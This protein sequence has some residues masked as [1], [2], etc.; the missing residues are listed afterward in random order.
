MLVLKTPFH[1]VP[2]AIK[3]LFGLI[4]DSMPILGFNRTPYFA[5]NSICGVSALFLIGSLAM[6]K[7]WGVIRNRT[8]QVSLKP[9]FC[10]VSAG[11]VHF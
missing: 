8:C 10:S 11:G 7:T 5:L 3:P 9:V 2:R 4:A 6:V 1:P